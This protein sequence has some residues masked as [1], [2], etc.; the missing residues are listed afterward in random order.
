MIS[1][2]VRGL[3]LL[4]WLLQSAA[5]MWLFWLWVFLVF[6][7]FREMEFAQHQ[8]ATY[9]LV[10]AGACLLELGRSKFTQRNLL[11]LDI[12][13]NHGV[14]FRQTVVIVG[15]LLLFLVAAKDMVISRLF[16]F[17]FA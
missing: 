5:I 14:S 4:H 1:N 7:V 17:T 6:H 3:N 12:V 13:Q 16:L 9:S 15:T 10:L 8:Y 11:Q 2:R